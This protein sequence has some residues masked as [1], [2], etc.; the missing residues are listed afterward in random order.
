MIEAGANLEAQRDDH[1]TPLMLAAFLTQPL[2]LRV[3]LDHQ[4]N[5]MPVNADGLNP[6]SLAVHGVL[7]INDVIEAKKV[8]WCVP[9][10]FILL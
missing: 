9:F 1:F 2:L 8:E 3:L 10:V 6:V 7:G 5:V 4:A